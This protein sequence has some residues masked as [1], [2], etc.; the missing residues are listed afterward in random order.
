MTAA[1]LPGAACIPAAPLVWID[2]LWTPE[3]MRARAFMWAMWNGQ[4]VPPPPQ[5]KTLPLGD[6][7]KA[8]WHAVG[9]SVLAG[10]AVRADVLE[11]VVSMLHQTPAPPEVNIA[12]SLGLPQ[13]DLPVALRVLGY[14]IERKEGDAV[15][16]IKRQARAEEVNKAPA[17]SSEDAAA[18]LRAA[19]QK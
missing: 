11:E 3:A 19:W 18:A 12:R 9:Y 1:L 7:P 8:A 4:P 17:P 16:Y 6:L 5:G 2:R 10:R 15:R 14:K 13:S